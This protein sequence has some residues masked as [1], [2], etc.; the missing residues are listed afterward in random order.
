[1]I[2]LSLNEAETLAAKAARG[3]GY[4]WGQADDIGRAA[5]VIAAEG[6]D[7]GLALLLLLQRREGFVAPTPERLALWR[8]GGPDIAG[9]LPL[10]PVLSAT[11]LLDAGLDAVGL[12]LIN[13]GLPVWLDALL[14]P[15]G[16]GATGEATLIRRRPAPETGKR[17]AVDAEVWRAL[18]E[19]AARTYVSE[20]EGSR[21][22]G[23]GG[24]RVDDE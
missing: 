2:G 10:C 12:T 17:A 4:A 8:D 19:Y 20:S 16:L 11:W 21:R 6:G 13:V 23:A 5:R 7:F 9:A 24:G 1:V 15:A 14:R 3:A 18:D 22:R